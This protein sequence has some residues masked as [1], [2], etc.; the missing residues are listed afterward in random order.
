MSRYWVTSVFT[1]AR[2]QCND[3]AVETLV[4]QDKNLKIRNVVFRGDRL[5]GE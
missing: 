5:S 4:K 3:L 2:A 1:D